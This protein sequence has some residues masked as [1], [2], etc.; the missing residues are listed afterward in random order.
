VLWNFVLDF[1][2]DMLQYP[3]RKPRICMVLYSKEQQIGKSAI[4]R[5][6]GEVLYGKYFRQ[7]D[8]ENH[9]LGD[10]TS[11][12]ADHIIINIDESSKHG[13]SYTLCGK[14]KNKISE[15]QSSITRKG[16]DQYYITSAHRYV[17]CINYK[18]ALDIELFDQRFLVLECD[19][20]H[21]GQKEAFD[22]I[23]RIINENK[24]LFWNYFR[25]RP[26]NKH[27]NRKI[28]MTDAKRSIIQTKYPSIVQFVVRSPKFWLGQQNAVNG[29][30][31]EENGAVAGPAEIVWHWDTLYQHYREWAREQQIECGIFKKAENLLE[32][33]QTIGIVPGADQGRV[34][35]AGSGKP[36]KGRDKGFRITREELVEH[37]R[38]FLIK[39]GE[40]SEEPWNP[41]T[42]EELQADDINEAN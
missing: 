8:D 42:D 1:F 22:N 11:V 2:C 24:A 29:G 39:M 38:S 34:R 32:P 17:Y 6:I 18:E 10:F 5:W 35:I 41:P 40:P 23:E 20:R 33:L 16:F 3:A 26:I 9:V 36:N 28:P 37:I 7:V 19:P 13:Q 30:G 14:L 12:L 25:K 31:S 4:I 15:P 21:R 27:W